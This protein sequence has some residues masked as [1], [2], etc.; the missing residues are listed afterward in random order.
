MLDPPF[1][2][3]NAFEQGNG[4]S[5]E[6][7]GPLTKNGKILYRVRGRRQRPLRRKYRRDLLPRRRSKLRVVHGAQLQFNAIGFYGRLDSALLYVPVPTTLAFSLGAKY[8]QRPQERYPALN[9]QGIFRWKRLS[10]A[11]EAYGKR[12]LSFKNWQLAYNVQLGVLAVKK[13]LLFGADFGQYLATD[14]EQ[15]P[16]SLS[17]DLRRQLQE[18]AARATANVF[19]WRD[20]FYASAFY[21]YRLVELSPNDQEI[22]GE[23]FQN[24]QEAKLVFTYR[25]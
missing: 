7:G 1:Y 22:Y 2:L 21:G 5:V 19:L 3:T 14:F 12:E 13:R 15:P 24:I 9:V 8:D 17:Y 11:A 18:M 23:D 4:A 10:L 6:F 25:F 16:V 20:V